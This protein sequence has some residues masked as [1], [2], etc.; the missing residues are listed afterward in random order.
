[1]ENDKAALMSS[2]DQQQ[3][4]SSQHPTSLK[5]ALLLLMPSAAHRPTTPSPLVP[6]TTP[7]PPTVALTSSTAV[8]ETTISSST[9]PTSPP[10]AIPSALEATLINSPASMVAPVLTP[11]PSPALASPLIS[12]R[13]P[14][15]PHS[16]HQK[17]LVSTRLR[18]LISPAPAIT[19]SPLHATI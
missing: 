14:I 8:P 4:H 7:S 3:G 1:M 15:R 16:T 19:P 18:P 17:R 9:A 10:S 11:S 12:A 2:L 6:V 5:S 13:L